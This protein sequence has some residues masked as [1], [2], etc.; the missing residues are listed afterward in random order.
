VGIASKKQDLAS[1]IQDPRSLDISPALTSVDIDPT[2]LGQLTWTTR[3]EEPTGKD[4][5]SSSHPPGSDISDITD[6]LRA[7][8]THFHA[9]ADMV[10]GLERTFTGIEP[11][12]VITVRLLLEQAILLDFNSPSTHDTINN[13]MKPLVRWDPHDLDD[14]LADK[15]I[16]WLNAVSTE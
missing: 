6:D 14:G 13:L 1:T 12:S 11:V 2:D 15:W 7:A 10:L 8:V 9:P 4:H 5:E 3:M 16:E